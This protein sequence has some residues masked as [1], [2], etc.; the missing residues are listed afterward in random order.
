MRGKGDMG[1][2]DKS[3]EITEDEWFGRRHMRALYADW[4]GILDTA[5]SGQALKVSG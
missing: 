4:N 2:R 5:Q 1:K 3:L